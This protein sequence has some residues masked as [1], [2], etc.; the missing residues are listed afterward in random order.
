MANQ[1]MPAAA[2]RKRVAQW[3]ASGTSVQAYAD[4]HRL[5]AVRLN[6]WVRRV[7]REEQSG[8]LVQVRIQQPAM[9]AARLELPACPDGRYV[10]IPMSSRHGWQPCCQDYSES[11]VLF[12]VAGHRAG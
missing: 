9:P 2:W 8:H 1:R 3:R 5:P 7:Q 11:F 4:E 6:Y 10:S 12:G